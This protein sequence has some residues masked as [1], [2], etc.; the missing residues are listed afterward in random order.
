MEDISVIIPAYN[1]S[2]S[3]LKSVESVLNQT[4]P[5]GE[6]IIADDASTD[7]TEEIIKQIE[8]SRVRYCRL[9]QNRGAGGARNF[10]A[11][12]ARFDIIAFHDSDDV[13]M[14]EK[15]EKQMKYWEEHPDCGLVY[16]AYEMQLIL[17]IKRIVPDVEECA[18]ENRKLEG[19]ILPDL[20]LRNSIGAPTMLLRKEV[21]E[22]AGGFDETMHSLEDWDFAIKAAKISRVGFVPEALMK[23]SSTEGGIS[24]AI[25]AFYQSRCYMLRKH[26]KD[27]SDLGQLEAAMKDILEKAERDG[28]LQQ[29]SQMM[30]AYLKQ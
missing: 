26:M 8:D 24:S 13:W 14:E 16:C 27:Y 5:V 25:G 19:W 1:R 12:Q 4:Y 2:A 15:I 7:N 17:G 23:V 11:A 18:L 30:M 22:Q 6:V 21:F 28:V 9:P 3:I 20:L 10:G 29:V